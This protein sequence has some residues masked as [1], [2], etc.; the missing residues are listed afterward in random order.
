M[1]R[2]AGPGFAVAVGCRGWGFGGGAADGGREGW[3]EEF[4]EFAGGAVWETCRGFEGGEQH[5]VGSVLVDEDVV[6]DVL[7]CVFED[8]LRCFRERG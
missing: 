6:D 8:L 4:G 2:F 1:A 3:F 5:F 7:E